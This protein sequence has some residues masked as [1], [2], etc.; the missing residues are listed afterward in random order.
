[1]KE[2]NKSA[3]FLQEKYFLNTFP[4]I[5][6]LIKRQLGALNSNEGEDLFQTVALRLWQWIT[7]KKERQLSAE[8]WQRYANRATCNE[9]R[10]FYGDKMRRKEISLS[11][12]TDDYEFISN[13][14]GAVEV[15]GNTES[16][17][18]SWWE[19][20]QKLSL[21]QKYALLL[22]K[23]DFIFEL[24]AARCCSLAEIAESLGLSR[25]ELLTLLGKQ[26][27][28]EQEVLRL[29]EMKTGERITVRQV[30]MA[31]GKAKAKL[32]AARRDVK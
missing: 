25:E 32:K 10:R 14:D 11:E 5:R 2:E 15:I 24:I 17:A 12:I 28:S 26:P 19:I 9:I 23:Q 30:W 20:I 7:R 29:I 3:R 27:F 8:D 4:L 16:E 6:H 18:C 31:R 13:S 22:F 21:R 1:M